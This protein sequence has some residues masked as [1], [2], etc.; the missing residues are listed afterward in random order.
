MSVL[1]DSELDYIK[2]PLT[3]SSI[4]SISSDLAK[5]QWTDKISDL[6]ELAYSLIEKKSINNGNVPLE[7][8]VRNLGL[9][10]GLK[11]TNCSRTYINI[12][13]RKTD[14]RTT[15]LNELGKCL[16]LRMQKD[17]EK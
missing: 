5:Y 11:I 10:F 7:E 17:D 3:L 4:A 9:F 2:N 13:R 12:K 6:V 15:F 16:N 8:F 14:S 1:L